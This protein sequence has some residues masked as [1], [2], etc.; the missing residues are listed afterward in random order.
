MYL[1]DDFSISKGDDAVDSYCRRV[2]FFNEFG[3]SGICRMVFLRLG[4]YMIFIF[5]A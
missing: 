5:D 1:V 3:Y 4:A 2:C